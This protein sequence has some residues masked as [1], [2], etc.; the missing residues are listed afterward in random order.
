VHMAAAGCDANRSFLSTHDVPC[1]VV[2]P[3]AGIALFDIT[4]QIRQQ[5][6]QLGVT[7]GYVNVLSRHT[8]TA[9]AINEYETRLLDDIRQVG[10]LFVVRSP[11]PT[12][13]CLGTC[14]L[15][16]IVRLHGQTTMTQLPTCVC[17]GGEGGMVGAK[18]GGG[19]IATG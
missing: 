1:Y 17:G 10:A 13:E 15:T 12:G 14:T 2:D 16:H 9:V 8:T 4:P 3:Y 19:E 5:V 11:V 18:E 7:E 6:Q